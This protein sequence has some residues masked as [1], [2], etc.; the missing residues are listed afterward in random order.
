MRVLA[1]WLALGTAAA[2]LGGLPRRPPL[3]RRRATANANDD[4]DLT[5]KVEVVVRRAPWDLETP[6]TTLQ[7]NVDLLDYLARRAQ[8]RGNATRAAEHWTR[9]VALA[10]GDGRAWL[11]LARQQQRAGR[12]EEAMALLRKALASSR[13]N[14][15]LLHALGSMEESRGRMAHAADLYGQATAADAG[16]AA[17]WLSLAMLE[18]RRGD[19]DAARELFASATRA[20]PKSYYAWTAWATFEARAGEPDAARKLFGAAVAAGPRSAAAYQSWAVAESRLGNDS[21]AVDLFEKGMAAH[22][23]NT[24]TLQAYAVHERRHG[25]VAHAVELLEEALLAGPHD[26]GVYAAYA[27]LV[28]MM[29]DAGA[30]RDLF[31]R[32]TVADPTALACWEQYSRFERRAGTDAAS[33]AAIL[34]QAAWANPRSRKLPRLFV[35]WAQLMYEAGDVPEARRRY[36]SA[37]ENAGSYGTT[38][39]R[40]LGAWARM[41]DDVGDPDAAVAL[42]ARA[43]A[44]RV[45]KPRRKRE[46]FLDAGAD[47]TPS[48][49]AARAAGRFHAGLL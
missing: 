29:G 28:E 6:A 36:Q 21:R 17:A 7:I 19:D 30:A 41:E 14:P 23:R 46:A 45:V 31:R 5:A 37:V 33:C 13:N 15:Y 47:G 3:A 38:A 24:Y 18:S 25:R 35:F 27:S 40:A 26:G 12:L 9:L 44:L 22:R 2:L 43:A 42:R 34:Q 8:K 20:S 10:P 39:S 49:M 11:G 4:A 48:E 1:S 32:G 16:H